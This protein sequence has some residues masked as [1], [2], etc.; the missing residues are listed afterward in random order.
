[1]HV[2]PFGGTQRELMEGEKIVKVLQAK[3]LFPNMLF[4]R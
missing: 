3:T 2:I 1:M 4:V